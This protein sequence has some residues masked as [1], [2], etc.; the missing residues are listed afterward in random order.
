MKCA[1]GGDSK[2]KL[3]SAPLVHV[4]KLSAFTMES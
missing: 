3:S 4:I 2:Y 1:G